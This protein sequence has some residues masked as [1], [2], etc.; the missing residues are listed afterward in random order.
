MAI[1]RI[2]LV[3]IA[4]V[5][6]A[7]ALIES[8]KMTV[9]VVRIIRVIFTTSQIV[10]KTFEMLVETAPGTLARGVVPALRSNFDCL[11]C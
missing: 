6:M 11:F 7:K 5:R 2:A 10:V 1:K 9:A 8:V 4:F 3:R